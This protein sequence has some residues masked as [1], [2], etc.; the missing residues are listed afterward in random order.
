MPKK[1]PLGW[2]DLMTAKR[3]SS[4]VVAYYWAPPTRARKAG[5]PLSAQALG[6]DYGA[7]KERCD[8]VLNKHYRAW[9]STGEQ[10]NGGDMPLG[11]F[12]WMSAVYK[13]SPKYTKMPPKTRVDYDHKLRLVSNIPLKNGK[14]F[15][16]L[17]LAS[18]SPGAADKI[19]AR[20]EDNPVGQPKTRTAIYAM[21][22]CGRAWNVARRIEP[23]LIPPSNPFERM[24][25]AY[26]PK[27]TKLFKHDD[28]VKFV[29]A[30]DEA[31]DWSIG[32]AAMI[33]F[34]WLQRLTDIVT[35]LSWHQYKPADA[36][37]K[38]KI[39]HHKTGVEIDI[40][41]YDDDGTPLWPELMYRL[42]H[43]YRHGPLIVMRDTPDRFKKVHL[44][45][46]LRH[47]SRRVAEIRSA[48]GIDPDIK[49][50]GLRHGGNSEGANAGLTDAQLRALSGHKT[51][52]ALLRYVPASAEQQKS[53]ARKRLESRTKKGH[54]SE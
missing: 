6:N 25:L 10:P 17:A 33:A 43:G 13:R 38:V 11:T 48:A 23:R 9:A 15:G 24:D 4:G 49:F 14:R 47:F 53:G 21:R 37:D 31:G 16:S 39:K 19:F 3:L 40:P 41:L 36:P 5:C 27:R 44:P 50:M 46:K 34:Y 22:V 29:K 42:D 45:W 52:A 1:K 18:I 20:L 26:S 7:A 54:L 30:A 51:T 35:R 8:T 2:P 12:D 28:L 32:T